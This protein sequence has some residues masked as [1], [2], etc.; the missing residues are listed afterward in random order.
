MFNNAMCKRIKKK[1]I[2]KGISQKQLAENVGST[3][4]YVNMILNGKC[5]NIKIETAILE[6]LGINDTRT[7]S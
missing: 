5:E 1:L 2:D 7:V 4:A 3:L 6:E